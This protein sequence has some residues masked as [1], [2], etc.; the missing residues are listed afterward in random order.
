[1]FDE[2]RISINYQE[3]WYLGLD[4]SITRAPGLVSA[5]S[6][7]T[8]VYKIMIE[9]GRD[10]HELHALMAPRPFLVSGGS[11]DDP[12]AGKRSATRSRS[13]ACS[14]TPIASA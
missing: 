13:T 1:V 9:Q 2:A 14:V 5:K 7:R 4:P 11:E 8:G 3:P 6:P 12:T 10:L